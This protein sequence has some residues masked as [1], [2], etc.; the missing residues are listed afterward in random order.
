MNDSPTLAVIGCGNMAEAILR[1]LAAAGGRNPFGRVLGYDPS[2]DRKKHL[3]GVAKL[4]YSVSAVNAIEASR[5]VL[6]ATK[7][8]V[9]AEAL[10]EVGG[11][12]AG[13][14]FVS[15]AAGTTT[16]TLEKL[17]PG[18]RVVR[19]MPN[20]PLM[21]G[22]GVVGLCRGATAT[23]DDLATAKTLFPSAE[24]FDLD[25]SQMDA[26][27][28]V[29]GSGPAYFFAFVEALAAAAEAEGFDKETAY[30]LAAATFTGSAALLEGSDEDA[31]ALRRRV[32]SP[33]GTTAAALTSLE[34]ADLTKI[35]ADAVAAA[36][37]RG[38]E[39]AGS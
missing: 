17:L 36:T 16:A 34:A 28:A 8:Q 20:T 22:R 27:T 4:N 30:R 1:G 7:P 18:G 39:L 38:R 29:S 6:I 24:L 25:E 10:A 37:R 19:T 14:L 2:A 13:R 33:N 21:V 15:I 31:A 11:V 12:A 32:T 35:V 26:L 23:A 9:V 5:V 3:V